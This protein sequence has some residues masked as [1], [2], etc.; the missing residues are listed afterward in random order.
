LSYT[1]EVLSFDGMITPVDRTAIVLT[2]F[3]LRPANCGILLVDP[4]RGVSGFM[5]YLSGLL[6]HQLAIQ[7]PKLNLFKFKL[8]LR[9]VLGKTRVTSVRIV[10]AVL[11]EHAVADITVTDKDDALE[12][13]SQLYPSHK[14]RI[15]KID[16]SFGE[17]S[18]AKARL[19][20]TRSGSISTAV[21]RLDITALWTVVE[22]SAKS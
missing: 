16:L 19:S 12:R 21:E 18:N 4:P 8:G 5:L 6:D 17:Q 22:E 11:T 10:G 14:G 9:P 15:G 7:A 2:K 3:L 13:A 20:I 1:E